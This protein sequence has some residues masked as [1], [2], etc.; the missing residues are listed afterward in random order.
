VAITVELP[1]AKR[2]PHQISTGQEG[3]L[4]AVNVFFSRGGCHTFL[5]TLITYHSTIWRPG[6][7]SCLPPDVPQEERPFFL[8]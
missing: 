7:L 3:T 4:A 5:F 1:P 8:R 6:T 2:N